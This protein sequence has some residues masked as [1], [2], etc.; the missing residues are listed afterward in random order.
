MK[1]IK[2]PDNLLEDNIV[3]KK[4]QGLNENKHS[5]VDSKKRKGLAKKWEFS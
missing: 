5:V 2:A 4:N 3:V 1:C